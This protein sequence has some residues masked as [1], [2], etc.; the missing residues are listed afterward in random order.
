MTSPDPLP[1]LLAPLR[2]HPDG[3]AV[4]TD[5]DGTLSSIVL[6]PD[7]ARP[8]PGAVDAL[9][10]LAG[11]YARVAVVSGRPAAFLAEHLHIGACPR[12]VAYGLYG[13]EWTD[14]E[15]VVEHP[16][17]ASWRETVRA[18]V[19]AA[20][21]EAPADVMVEDK[22]L[23]VTIHVRVVPKESD[24]AAGWV[25]THAADTGLVVHPA[26][27]SFE[28]RPPVSVDKGTVVADLVDGMGAAC[29]IGDDLGDL[30]AFD[31]LDAA[32]LA[33][34]LHTLKVAVRSAEAPPDLLERADLKVDGPPGALELLHRLAETHT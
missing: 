21:V 23:A 17:A 26:R 30:P 2:D 9:H 12:L 1:A 14:G 31:A 19:A 13:L 34:G 3:A 15:R 20:R 16:D 4:I 11:A 7:A 18:T 5:F 6:D 24:W 22:G 32:T 8:L 28:L 25:V 27:K 33:S 29:F 10:A